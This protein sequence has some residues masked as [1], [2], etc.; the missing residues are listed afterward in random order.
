VHTVIII[1]ITVS[2]LSMSYA[3]RHILW[4]LQR[5]I[6][7]SDNS[8]VSLAD[9]ASLHSGCHL[10]THQQVMSYHTLQHTIP[11]FNE[12]LCDI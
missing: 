2:Y 10:S 5:A 1:I 4:R 7:V 9:I 6:G 12:C 3:Q 11:F 8:L